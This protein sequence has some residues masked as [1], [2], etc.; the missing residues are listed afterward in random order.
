MIETENVT[1]TAA[2]RASD[3]LSVA[4]VNHVA[5]LE[6]CDATELA[7]PLYESIDPDALDALFRAGSDGY[8]EF[9]YHGY[10]IRVTSDGSIDV[11][12][13]P[14]DADFDRDGSSR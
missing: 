1:D 7:Y 2:V 9:S 5:A 13:A 8:L 14:V 6:G 10:E 12:P 3:E 11:R 4:V